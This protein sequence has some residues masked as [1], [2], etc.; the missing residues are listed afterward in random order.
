MPNF[1]FTNLRRV[2]DAVR[3]DARRY[4]EF[5]RAG[6]DRERVQLAWDSVDL[7][8]EQALLRIPGLWRTITVSLILKLYKR[9]MKSAKITAQCFR[10]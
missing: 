2:F 10:L 6:C 3:G 4:G 5:C 7:E 9:E 1:L 8:A